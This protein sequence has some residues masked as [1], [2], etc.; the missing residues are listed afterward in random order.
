MLWVLPTLLLWT[1]WA[2][3]LVCALGMRWG[4]LPGTAVLASIRIAGSPL[5]LV[6]LGLPLGHLAMILP[7]G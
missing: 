2:R 7:L 3:I 1:F 5:E 4:N 6:R